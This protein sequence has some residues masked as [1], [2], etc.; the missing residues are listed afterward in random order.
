MCKIK[1]AMLLTPEE[2]GWRE[3]PTE[4]IEDKFYSSSYIQSVEE[5]M[6]QKGIHEDYGVNEYLDE[7]I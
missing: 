6:K 5:H 3:E 2:I 4:I 1:D 7:R